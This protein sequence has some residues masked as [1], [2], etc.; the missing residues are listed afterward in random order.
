MSMVAGY[1]KVSYEA[2]K[3]LFFK[4]GILNVLKCYFR[5]GS[6]GVNRKYPVLC[7]NEN[8]IMPV[9]CQATEIKNRESGPRKGPSQTIARN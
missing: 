3:R 7:W 2:S 5:Y 1:E 8:R 9:G 6:P 4:S